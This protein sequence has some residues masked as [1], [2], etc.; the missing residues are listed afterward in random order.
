MWLCKFFGSG[1][2]LLKTNL[3]PLPLPLLLF[4]RRKREQ[5]TWQQNQ[6]THHCTQ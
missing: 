3:I 5:K 2:F 4:L 6:I 1:L